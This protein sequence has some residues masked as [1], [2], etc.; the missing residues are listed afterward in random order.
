MTAP[1]CRSRQRLRPVTPARRCRN[2]SIRRRVE[3]E[4][5]PK[6]A[7]N[8]LIILLDDVGFGQADTFGGEIHT[9]TLTRLR[10]RGHQ[11][12]PLSHH[13]DLLAHAR[14]AAHRAQS[15]ARRQRHHRRAGGGLGRL[16]G[17]DPENIGD[18]RR[19]CCTITATSPPPSANGTTR[20][21]TRPPRWG[22]FDRW[23]TGHGFDYFYGFLAGETSQWEPRLFEN[24]HSHRAAARREVSSHRG[25]GGQGHHVAAETSRLFSGQAVL[26]VLGDPAAPTGRTMSRRSG[27]TNTK[28]SS[29]TAGTPTASVFSSGRRKWAGFRRTPN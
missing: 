22:P 12:Q 20:P 27:P 9:P 2:P 21:P 29:T 7:P 17:R 8:V 23:P 13:L 16:H 1:C 25:P 18:D 6:D 10:D 19:R 11:L 24:L 3:P 15:P 28:A 14:G 4:R 5:L 26:P